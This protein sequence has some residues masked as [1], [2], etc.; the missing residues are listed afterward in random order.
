MRPDPQPYLILCLALLACAP[1]PTSPAMSPV[2]ALVRRFVEAQQRVMRPGAGEAEI[3]TLLALLT[4]SVTYEHPRARATIV[5]RAAIGEGLH[6]FLGTTRNPV[7]T[8]IRT[9]VSGPVVVTEQRVTFETQLDDTWRP[10]GRTQ[11]TLFDIEDGKIA[12][13][14]DFWQP[15]T[16]R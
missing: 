8:V 14:V 12:R 1:P 13:I 4:D 9:L 7:I 2:E 16:G 5:G 6:G 3:Q 11:I 15:T 10:D